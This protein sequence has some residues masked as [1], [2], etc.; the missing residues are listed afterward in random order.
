[1]ASRTWRLRLELARLAADGTLRV[2]VDQIFP[3]A[4][5]AAAHRAIMPGHALG[6]VVL[7]P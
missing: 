5:A 2:F 1:V 7:I 4:D 3:L 6:K